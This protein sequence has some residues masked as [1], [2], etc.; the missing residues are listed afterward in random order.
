MN[1]RHAASVAVA[2]VAVAGGRARLLAHQPHIVE[3]GETLWSIAVANNFTTRALA[4]SN[5]LSEDSHLQAGQKDP[6]PIRGGGRERACGRGLGTATRRRPPRRALTQSDAAARCW[7]RRPQWG[8]CHSTRLDER[9]RKLHGTLLA[10]TALK[11]PAG[12]SMAASPSPSPTQAPDATPQP[13]QAEGHPLARPADRVRAR[14]AAVAR[15]GDRRAGER[16][17]QRV[18]LARERPRRHADPPWHLGVRSEQPRGLPTRPGL[19]ARQRPRRRSRIWPSS[20]AT[21]AA[22]RSRLPPPTTRASPLSGA[23]ACCRKRL[24]Y[25]ANVMALRAKYGG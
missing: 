6:D 20:C 24:T 14:G 16:L 9:A 3:P 21:Q 8:E 19:S 17:Q 23:S 1:R 18:H 11:L 25:V 5:G 12:A 22:T 2:L 10:G 4:A 7:D 13:T 15:G